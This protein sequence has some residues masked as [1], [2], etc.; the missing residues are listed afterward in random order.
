[1]L[2]NPETE[3][4][5]GKV[6]PKEA[7]AVLADWAERHEISL[8]RADWSGAGYSDAKLLGVY[9]QEAGQSWRSLIIKI[10]PPGNRP[11]RSRDQEP[12]ATH[13]AQ[14][15]S[16]E[17][18]RR[19]L[20]KPVYDPLSFAQ[21]GTVSFQA[22]AGSGF[23]NLIDFTTMLGLHDRAA[24]T[25]QRIVASLLT[26]WNAEPK[27]SE[28]ANAGV[29]LREIL[30]ERLDRGGTLDSHARERR[31]ADDWLPHLILDGHTLVNP[32]S[33]A[34]HPD[35]AGGPTLLTFRGNVHGDLHEGNLLVA[36][37]PGPPLDFCLV[38]LARYNETGLLPWDP[39]YLVVTA[40]AKQV[41]SLS[42]GER[43]MLRLSLLD[44]TL[45]RRIEEPSLR[46]VII[47]VTDAERDYANHFGLKLEWAR[48]RLVCI[49]AAGLILSARRLLTETA[50]DWCFGLAAHAATALIEQT[51]TER[52]V[53]DYGSDQPQIG[54]TLALPGGRPSLSRGPARPRRARPSRP[55]WRLLDREHARGELHQ[56]LTQGPS[57]MIIVKGD[58]GVGKSLLVDEVLQ[59]LDQHGV[60]VHRHEAFRGIPFDVR[61]L[62][63]DLMGPG[64]PDRPGAGPA[65]QD[66]EFFRSS[67][68][69]L[70]G[71]MLALGDTPVVIVI[72]SA[73]NLVR[74]GGPVLTDLDLDEAFEMLAEA[75]G[76]RVSVV[77]VSRQEPQSPQGSTWPTAEPPIDVPTLDAT[78]FDQ[79]LADLDT[80]LQLDLS[81]LGNSSRITFASAVRRNP[82]TTE[83]ACSILTSAVS[84][85]QPEALVT[86]LRGQRRSEVPRWIADRLVASC[87]AVE[88]SVLDVLAAF[89]TSVTPPSIAAVLGGR[90]SESQ[91]GAGLRR[92]TKRSIVR[93]TDDDRYFL[94][95]S[96]LRDALDAAL[97]SGDGRAKPSPLLAEAAY[98]LRRHRADPPRTLADLDVTFA[99]L[100]ALIRA[101]RYVAAYPVIEW[102]DDALREWHCSAILLKHREQIVGELSDD[103]L[104]MANANQLAHLYTLAGDY[105]RAQ[106]AYARA[107]ARAERREDGLARIVLGINSASLDRQRGCSDDARRGY[108]AALDSI[109][110]TG[111]AK[112]VVQALEGLADCERRQGRYTEAITHATAAIKL[113]GTVDFPDATETYA[114]VSSRQ[115]RCRLKLASWYTELGAPEAADKQLTAAG[116][117]ARERGDQWLVGSCLEGRADLLLAQGDLRQAVAAATEA[118]D[119]ALRTNDAVTLL[120][121]RTTLCTAYLMEN[122]GPASPHTI[123]RSLRY[124]R[125]GHSLIVL[126]V[127][128]LLAA[129]RNDDLGSQ[130]LFRRL[131]DE[132][133][134]RIQHDDLDFSAHDF[135]ALAV[136]ALEAHEEEAIQAAARR[137]SQ[138]RNLTTLSTP[139]LVDRL[140]WMLGRLGDLHGSTLQLSPAMAVLLAARSGL[141]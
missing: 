72:E 38:D 22:V 121:A 122:D 80:T 42:D 59:D 89:R 106:D 134:D 92:L 21:G 58:E 69:R 133:S 14:R 90:V 74:P 24:A 16:S 109:S 115:I 118:E 68:A 73:E 78:H 103:H 47:G 2:L 37:S 81:A 116:R 128:A 105:P 107:L 15:L 86:S 99:E 100:E 136:C 40:A 10:K 87:D 85:L 66:E 45:A 53:E 131:R 25:C 101:R 1:V 88:R 124:R 39:V 123:E 132:A 9:A 23:G 8:S 129:Q 91:L 34:S 44:P 61:T 141:S 54:P 71:A 31:H 130:A 112:I 27:R 127:C 19:H 104:E 48:L 26:E 94:P 95:A 138:A 29:L 18:G 32:F 57:G 56:R 84:G 4:I 5:I 30:G 62:T 75:E 108:Q 13:A 11:P 43:E 83:F 110:R 60:R 55:G 97:E 113:P 111:P 36:K 41:T 96:Y 98:E 20:A 65:S 82:R 67:V 126:A 120:R 52:R 64:Q 139:A 125:P 119:H 63:D 49:T 140:V 6:E 46:R 79:F 137:F 28:P 33:L 102:I 117:Q 50:R 12:R 35:D 3:D 7:R 76:H 114:F 17:F 51:S 77:L 70:E 135:L 93:V